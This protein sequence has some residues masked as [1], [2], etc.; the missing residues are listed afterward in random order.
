M[1]SD[2]FS[3]RHF[4][5]QAYLYLFIMHGKYNKLKRRTFL[6]GLLENYQGEAM[7][8]NC[9]ILRH[10]TYVFLILFS[11]SPASPGAGEGRTI[12]TTF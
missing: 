10:F 11:Q 2:H 4:K 1:K 5:Y 12:H 6:G 7:T 9:I 8:F 3:T